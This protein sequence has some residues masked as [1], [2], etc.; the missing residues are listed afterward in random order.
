MPVEYPQLVITWQYVVQNGDVLFPNGMRVEPWPGLPVEERLRVV[1]SF[2]Q[3]LPL[4]KFERAARVAAELKLRQGRATPEQMAGAYWPEG[5][6]D[7]IRSDQAV[8]DAY[9]GGAGAA[10]AEGNDG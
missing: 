9:L 7:D 4:G 1:A 8:V 3:T 6:P 5:K 10:P 2:V